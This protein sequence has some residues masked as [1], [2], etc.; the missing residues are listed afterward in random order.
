MLP[1]YAMLLS[2]VLGSC[3]TLLVQV[4]LLYRRKPEPAAG[5]T[6]PGPPGLFSSRVSPDSSLKDYFVG[7]VGTSP[8]SG[9]AN[10]TPTQSASKQALPAAQEAP[11]V[12]STEETLYWLNAICFFLFRELRDT[13]LVRH[14][15]TRKI[16]V[17]FEELLQTK[18][19]GKVLEGLS[20]RDVCL[21]DVVPVF[22][23]VKLLRPVTCTED[24]CPEELD[25]E[26]DMEYSGGFHLAID[27]DLVFGKSAYLFV[28]ITKMEG[29]VRLVFTRLPFTH[30]SFTFVDEPLMDF[31]V[32]SQFEGRPLPQ[33]ASI[34]VNQ[35]KKVIRR[36]HTLP[37]YKIRFKPFFPFQVVPH[38]EYKDRN[39]NI[40]NF[41]LTEGRLKVSLMECTRLL[42]FGSYEREIPIHCLF[43]LSEKVWE[44]K[45][46]TSVKTAELLKGSS[47][48]VGLTLRQVQAKE[49]EAGYVVI[50][51]ITPNSAAANADLQRGD[52]LIAIG[53]VKITSTIH[54]LKLIKQAGEKVTV[55]YER[56]VGSVT[57]ES[58]AMLEEPF[59]PDEDTGST[60]TES[61]LKELDLEF[62]DLAN[63]LKSNEPR[64]ESSTT[65]PKHISVSGAAKSIGTISPILN[66]KLQMG[67]STARAIF[68]EAT[69]QVGSKNAENPE[70]TNRQPQASASKPPVPPR[71]QLKISPHNEVQN[72]LETGDLTSEKPERPPPPPASNGD[73]GS[74][75]LKNTDGQEEPSGAKL[76]TNKLEIVKEPSEHSQGSKES[77]ENHHSWE[78]PEILYRN[79]SGK[80]ARTKGSS[81]IFEVEKQHQY[82]N[83]AV[84]CRD[85]FKIGGL[86][87]LGYESIKLEEIALDCIATASMEFFRTFRLNPPAPKATVSRTA[88]RTLTSHKGFNEKFCYGDITIHFKYLRE[89]EPEDSSFLL[90]KEREYTSEEAIAPTLPKEDPYFGHII[91]T[92]NK[93]NFQDTQFQNPTWCDYCK[94]KVWTKAASQCVI[95]AY[96]CHKKCQERCLT[97][98]PFCLGSSRRLDGVLRSF[99]LETQDSQSTAMPRADS[100]LKSVNKTTGIT[101]HLINTSTRLL[102]LRQTPKYRASEQGPEPAEP[103]PKPTPHAS[104]NEG[105][106]TEIG[107]SSSPTKRVARRGIKL[108]RK[109]GGLDDSVFIAVKEIG[110][111]LYRSLPTEERIQKLE[112]MLEKLQNEID[113]ELENNNSLIKEEKETTD[114]RK[115]SLLSAALAKSGERLQALTLLMIHYRA[116]I[117]DIEALENTGLD[118]ESRKE[119]KYEEEKY[120]DHE[121]ENALV[122]TPILETLL[123]AEDEERPNTP[124]ESVD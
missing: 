109:E 11:L 95:C 43:E 64:D 5:P 14:W 107:G 82:L 99:K 1:V 23:N 71:P 55:Y 61:D 124:Q 88:L 92:E 46:R 2:A 27:A 28:R 20:L 40:Q 110:R 72:T 32:K 4:L 31:E 116:G 39:L 65:S 34:I 69:K 33:L 104:D 21:G 38:D 45:P 58:F 17:E 113:Q 50:E 120:E 121:D 42:I 29:R 56:P 70:Q 123:K 12:E 30:W 36:K 94:K 114:A 83:V 77:L 111:D 7:H 119:E 97:D 24:S 48:S 118:L 79:R 117:E 84:W 76:V 3:L 96:V 98:T 108:A 63:D 112:V 66:R 91:Y 49:G 81:Y 122:M 52:R 41:S 101:R 74:E 9:S 18:V 85:P 53:G 100:E 67:H 103:S 102:N 68:K 16:K 62:E 15:V 25:F 26:V 37:H 8:D 22:R 59:F 89:G 51:T 6:R 90:D 13:A 47:Q 105:S 75:K 35:F 78:S 93:H 80:W 10:P 115:K 87:C 57:Q 54:V 19:T 60:S 86:L 106:D 44:E 73:K